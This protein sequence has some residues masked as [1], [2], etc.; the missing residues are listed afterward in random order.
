ME[1]G[2]EVEGLDDKQRDMVFTAAAAMLGPIHYVLSVAVLEEDGERFIE[3]VNA[4]HELADSM[5][6]VMRGCC[7]GGIS[8]DALEVLQ[9]IQPHGEVH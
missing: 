7:E 6:H 2:I 3:L 5:M 1:F 9:S 8:P 4:A